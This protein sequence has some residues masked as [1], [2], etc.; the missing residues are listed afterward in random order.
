MYVWWIDERERER[1]KFLKNKIDND[2]S[3]IFF[4]FYDDGGVCVVL[5]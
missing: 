3:S 4:L 1:E 5:I 2:D